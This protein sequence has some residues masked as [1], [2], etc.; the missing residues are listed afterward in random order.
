VGQSLGLKVGNF[1]V[2]PKLSVLERTGGIAGVSEQLRLSGSFDLQILP[3]AIYPPY[4]AFGNAEVWGAL[5]SDLPHPAVVEDVDEL[6]NLD[7][8][9]GRML[10]PKGDLVRYQLKGKLDDGSSIELGAAKIGSWMYVRGFTTPPPGSADFFEYQ[11]R[12]VAR[13]GPF[14]DVNDDGVVDAADYT[15]LRDGSGNEGA[16]AIESGTVGVTLADWRAQYGETVPDFDAIDALMFEP[17][18][19]FAANTAAVPEPSSA[20]LMLWAIAAG[21]AVRCR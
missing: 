4:V 10:V 16:A 7:E 15:L 21:C 12:M 19:G 5:V 6:L 17:A 1:K 9:H 2:I 20:V 14:A 11:L 13:S 3:P 8:L 18:S